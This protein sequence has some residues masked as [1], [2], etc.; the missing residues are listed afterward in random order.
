[1]FVGTNVPSKCVEVGPNPETGRKGKQNRSR[2]RDDRG[3]D[4]RLRMQRALQEVVVSD[5]ASRAAGK[6]AVV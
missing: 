4:E 5:D 6:A 1:M 2:R 3:R